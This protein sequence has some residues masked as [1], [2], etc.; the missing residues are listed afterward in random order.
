MVEIHKALRDIREGQ[1]RILALTDERTE[2]DKAILSLLEQLVEASRSGAGDG[3]VEALTRLERA[4]ADLAKLL[5]R[6]AVAGRV[7]PA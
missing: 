7:R 5:T 1:D 2:L 6:G 4:V 3:M